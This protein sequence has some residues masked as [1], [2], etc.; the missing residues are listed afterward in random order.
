M[1]P[2]SNIPS[3]TSQLQR[4]KSQL[5]DLVARERAHTQ[6][7][8]AVIP[9]SPIEA[10]LQKPETPKENNNFMASTRGCS[11]YP[12]DQLQMMASQLAEA[13]RNGEFP[14]TKASPMD[15]DATIEDY[16]ALTRLRQLRGNPMCPAPEAYNHLR[17][18]ITRR[19]RERD[20]LSG[21]DETEGAAARRVDTYLQAVQHENRYFA[22]ANKPMPQRRVQT[23]NKGNN[24]CNGQITKSNANG[25]DEK[26]RSMVEQ[27]IEQGIADAT[28]PLRMNVGKLDAQAS[29]L[30]RQSD[31]MGQQ[32]EMQ[33]QTVSALQTMIQ[34]QAFNIQ[35]T[36]QNLAMTHGLANQLSQIANDL[37][38]SINQAVNSALQE[39]T[40]AS[41][42]GLLEAQR[43]AIHDIEMRTQRLNELNRE[44]EARD[45]TTRS[46][47]NSTASARDR[48]KIQSFFQKTF[49][50]TN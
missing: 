19:I 22:A 34:P 43:Q 5:N 21:D 27:T 39:H 17:I 16:Q 46:R 20:A 13:R 18:E 3:S 6:A 2:P 10:F 47:T 30:R 48:S 1:S 23:A 31:T 33:Q 42:N 7:T 44:A 28:G 24:G 15:V 4:F 45:S 9:E 50:R 49:G 25:S 37:P 38:Q 11:T 14:T 40:Q 36:T 29:T 32:I 35:A 8:A 12:T 41:L 26:M